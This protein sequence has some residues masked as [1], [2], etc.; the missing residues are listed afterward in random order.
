MPVLL[1]DHREE[2]PDMKTILLFWHAFTLSFTAVLMLS[3][4][5]FSVS[6]Q[7]RFPLQ[8]SFHADE[9]NSALDGGRHAF[10]DITVSESGRV[11]ITIR[12]ENRVALA[13]YCF[14]SAYFFRDAAGNILVRHDAPQLCTDGTHVPFSGPSRRQEHFVFQLQE[15]VRR[16]VTD[17]VVV[18]GPGSRDPAELLGNTLRRGVGIFRF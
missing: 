12:V 14:R 17:I 13:G 11:D 1:R 15:D 10:S 7:P 4:F 18:H 9:G 5:P 3:S 6:A 8:F 16:R 2:R